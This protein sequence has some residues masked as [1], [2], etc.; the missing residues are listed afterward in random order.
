MRCLPAVLGLI[1]VG[2]CAHILR[3]P[4]DVPQ[5]L[6]EKDWRRELVGTWRV[7]SS[8]DSVPVPS[9]RLPDLVARD[10]AILHISDSAAS[11]F[12]KALL[13]RVMASSGD[14]GSGGMVEVA[15]TR[16]QERRRIRFWPDISDSYFGLV[17]VREG[18]CF[19]GTWEHES[20]GR[21]LAAGR[22]SMCRLA[23]P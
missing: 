10:S 4:P 2:G 11:P 1:L 22:F 8:R 3:P 17:G 19:H 13:A 12:R 9:V 14:T 20:W 7:V 6:Q 18:D 21:I 16:D 5:P 15:L 23:E